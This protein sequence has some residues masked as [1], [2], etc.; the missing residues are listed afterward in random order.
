MPHASRMT[1]AHPTAVAVIDFRRQS[2]ILEW[3]VL[4]GTWTA[5]D[6]PPSLVHGIALI[7][8]SQPNICIYGRGGRL[9]LQMGPDHYELS[10]DS[11][12]IKCTRSLASFGLRKR[13]AVESDTGRVLFSH[14]FWTGQGDDFFHWLAVNAADPEWRSTNRRRWSE[15][16]DASVMR[17]C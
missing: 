12:R 7:R 17:A 14:S 8:A 15:G 6:V 10:E 3:N 5:C 11:P 2:M 4:D 13:F 9:N 1:A 16:L